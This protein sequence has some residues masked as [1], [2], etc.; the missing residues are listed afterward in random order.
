[1]KR[2]ITLITVAASALTMAA[3]NVTADDVLSTTRKVNNYF[4]GKYS[5]PTVPT[6]VKRVR[7][8]SLFI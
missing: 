6:N 1:M 3:Q 2:L 4:M 7:P 5:D 8:S